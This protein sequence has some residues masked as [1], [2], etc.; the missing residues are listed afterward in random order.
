[1]MNSNTKHNLYTVLTI[2]E[3]I[4]EARDFKTFVFHD[5]HDIHYEAGQYLTLVHNTENDEIRRSYSITSSPVLNEPLSI[6]VKRVT[7]GIFSRQLIDRTKVGDALLTSGVGGFFRLPDQMDP[8]NAI[9]FFA[10]G[11]GITPIVSLL[12]TVL[13]SNHSIKV[14]LVY[15]NSSPGFVP[16]H[17]ILNHLQKKFSS[18]FQIDYLF[19]TTPDLRKAHLNRDYIIQYWNEHQI[20]YSRSLFYICGPES[21]MR[22]VTY[23]LHLRGVADQYIRRE[24]F[25][26]NKI[27]SS[28]LKPPDQGNYFVTLKYEDREYK[29]KVNYPD[30][31]LL[32]AKKEKISLPYSC[33]TGKCG[34][35]AALCLSGEVWLS[36]NEVLT[37]K[38]LKKGLTL[39]CVG[40]P[41]NGDVILKID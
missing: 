17:T 34:N 13:H 9:I 14:F 40:H 12:K 22:M 35:C 28:K 26:P 5:D 21:Y 41:I 29:L 30:T 4:E 32:A 39:T 24:D 25:V 2:K 19:G 15:S 38:E 1:M 36:N 31:I 23:V 6:G 11:A 16:Y 3:I 18:R 8:Y 20:D 33:E 7:N 27:I 37:D 10:A